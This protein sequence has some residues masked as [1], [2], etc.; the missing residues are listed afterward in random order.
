MFLS[1]YLYRHKDIVSTWF[2]KWFEAAGE[3]CVKWC[4]S[5]AK[6][7]AGTYLMPVKRALWHVCCVAPVGWQRPNLGE[8]SRCLLQRYPCSHHSAGNHK[9]FLPGTVLSFLSTKAWQ[10]WVGRHPLWHYRSPRPLPQWTRWPVL[11][12]WPTPSEPLQM[13]ANESC[14][15]TKSSALSLTMLLVLK[16]HAHLYPQIQCQE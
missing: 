7:W 10:M 3:S 16:C 12:E 8:M 11:V 15:T 2:W 9:T 1:V 13:Q 6:G 14:G 4:L 5:S